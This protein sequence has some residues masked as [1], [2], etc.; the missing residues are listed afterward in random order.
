MWRVLQ[1]KGDRLYLSDGLDS[2]WVRTEG[3]DEILEYPSW[4]QYFMSFDFRRP[5]I[6]CP[7]L[8]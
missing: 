1:R 4:S 2:K 8:R 7:V 5:D 3:V 6:W